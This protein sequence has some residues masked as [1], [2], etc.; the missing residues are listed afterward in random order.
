MIHIFLH[1]AFACELADSLLLQLL[2]YV[3]LALCL[4]FV[5]AYDLTKLVFL[6]LAN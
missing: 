4:P 1:Q 6:E 2:V 3:F 5:S